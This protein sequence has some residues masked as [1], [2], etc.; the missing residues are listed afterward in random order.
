MFLSGHRKAL[1]K[2]QT[3]RGY[4][5]LFQYLQR[6]NVDEYALV[7]PG[8]PGSFKI[9]YDEKEATLISDIEKWSQINNIH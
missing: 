9:P 6:K 5:A 4:V 2:N 8:N 3:Q 1:Y 7:R